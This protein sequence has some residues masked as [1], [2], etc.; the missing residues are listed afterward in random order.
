M[1]IVHLRLGPGHTLESQNCNVVFKGR[2][3]VHKAGVQVMWPG[4]VW[5][6]R[7]QTMWFLLGLAS[8]HAPVG[9]QTGSSVELV[10]LALQL[11]I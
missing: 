5:S 8:V 10:F 11:F 2:C 3:L 7:G 1:H 9:G 6:L 4:P